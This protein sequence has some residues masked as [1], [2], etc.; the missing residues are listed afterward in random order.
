MIS[1]SLLL[2]VQEVESVHTVVPLSFSRVSNQQDCLH[3]Y[4][5]IYPIA[6]MCACVC[7]FH[8]LVRSRSL[9]VPAFESFLFKK[10]DN[11]LLI[12]G[13]KGGG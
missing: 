8:M 13:K 2:V 1:N 12:E 4:T 9:C 7:V 10:P 5:C 11:G 6:C 3:V